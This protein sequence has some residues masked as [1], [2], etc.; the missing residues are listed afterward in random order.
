[1]LGLGEW[2]ARWQFDHPREHELD[3]ELLMWWVHGRLDL[4]ALPSRRLVFEFDFV[5]QRRRFWIVS[6]ARG[7]SVCT[8]DPGF[9][10]DVTIRTELSV[11]YEVWFGQRLLVDAIRDGRVELSGASGIVRHMPTVLQ[12]SPVAPIVT[13]VQ[14]AG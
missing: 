12:L 2:G 8:F 9:E 14:G 1:V 13:A 4:S 10:V 7:P 6:D 3:P 11:L 5:D